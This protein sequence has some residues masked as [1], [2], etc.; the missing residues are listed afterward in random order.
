MCFL[1][2]RQRCYLFSKNF[3]TSP[4]VI[5]IHLRFICDCGFIIYALFYASLMFL[6]L[7]LI[8]NWSMT[9][10]QALFSNMKIKNCLSLYLHNTLIIN[11][12][13]ETASFSWKYSYFS[14]KLTIEWM[15]QLNFCATPELQQQYC[16]DFL[17]TSYSFFLSEWTECWLLSNRVFFKH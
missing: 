8:K 7:Q 16:F 10:Y 1:E 11:F 14:L 2:P 3:N 5:L 12:Y 4:P 17:A 6:K 9:K 13:N 15:G